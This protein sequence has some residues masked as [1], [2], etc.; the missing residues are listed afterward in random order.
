M[1]VE[2]IERDGGKAWYK[3]VYGYGRLLRVNAIYAENVPDGAKRALIANPDIDEREFVSKM[4]PDEL[5]RF[6]AKTGPA[7]IAT[8]LHSAHDWDG[9][10]A[11]KYVDET[12]P[13]DVAA[14]ILSRIRAALT[15]EPQSQTAKKNS[16]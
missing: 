14:E 15:G 8:V 4:T 5:A 7:I 16:S 6:N 10:D 13:S 9:L 12:L 1:T 2:T 11:D 3:I